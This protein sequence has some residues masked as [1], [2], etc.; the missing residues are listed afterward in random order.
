MAD[1]CKKS[2]K[3]KIKAAFRLVENIIGFRKVTSFAK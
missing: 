2:R 3:I 1:N